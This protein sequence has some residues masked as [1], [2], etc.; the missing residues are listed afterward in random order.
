M[1]LFLFI[2]S[3]DVICLKRGIEQEEGGMYQKIHE[4]HILFNLRQALYMLPVFTI[5]NLTLAC[6]VINKTIQHGPSQVDLVL[7]I[8]IWKAKITCQKNCSN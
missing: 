4:M 8:L 3:V 5:C 2:N 7:G 1:F 6:I